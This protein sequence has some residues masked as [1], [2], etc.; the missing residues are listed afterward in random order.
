MLL[1][2]LYWLTFRGRFQIQKK[3]IAVVGGKK[4]RSPLL[5]KTPAWISLNQNCLRFSFDLNI[6][7]LVSV[8][9]MQIQPNS[10]LPSLVIGRIHSWKQAYNKKFK[11]A[12]ERMVS[13]LLFPTDLYNVTVV[14]VFLQ[15]RD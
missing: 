3:K 4:C 11:S 15:E 13:L 6:I 9:E 1:V 2:H 12:S 5:S 10:F 8:S 7:Y 14:F